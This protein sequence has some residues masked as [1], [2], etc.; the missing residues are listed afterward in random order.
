ML[1][2]SKKILAWV[3]LLCMVLSVSLN[4]YTAAA[5]ETLGGGQQ[6][7]G[8]Q[9]AGENTEGQE[10]MNN[11]GSGDG[12]A[13][14]DSGDIANTRGDTNGGED[15][16]AAKGDEEG[17][18]WPQPLIDV[19]DGYYGPNGSVDLPPVRVAITEGPAL[20][21]R[22]AEINASQVLA[23]QTLF[24]R[25]E[26]GLAQAKNFADDP[27]EEP[28]PLYDDFYDVNLTVTLP[29]GL[30]LNENGKHY[31]M[32]SVPDNRDLSVPHTYTITLPPNIPDNPDT[33]E[34]ESRYFV[35]SEGFDLQI[36]V[37]N[38]G[39]ANS[40]NTYNLANCVTLNAKFDVV[41]KTSELP[42]PQNAVKTYTYPATAGMDPITT[43]TPDVW[44]VNK[45]ESKPAAVDQNSNIVTYEWQIDVGLVKGTDENGRSILQSDGDKYTRFGADEVT[46]M[47]LSDA[48][49]V[50]L[51]GSDT[52]YDL[53]PTS[54]TIKKTG[55]TTTAVTLYDAETNLLGQPLVVWGA[56]AN[57]NLRLNETTAV[58]DKDGDK[59]ADTTTPTYTSYIVTA[60]YDVSGLTGEFY[61]D[62]LNTLKANNK[63]DL[64]ATLA[65]GKA[66][67][68]PI[69]Q[70]DDDDADSVAT[71][72]R[73]Q[74]AKI[75]IDKMLWTVSGGTNAY[76]GEFGTITYTL[77]A[78]DDSQFKVYTYDGSAYSEYAN[79]TSVTITDIE[80]AY[81]VLPLPNGASYKIKE[82]IDSSYANQMHFDSVK[83]KEAEAA[84]SEAV[85]GSNGEVSFAVERGEEWTVTFTN[86]E[87]K[88]KIE[89]TKHDEK[90][91]PL[92]NTQFQL[93]DSNGNVVKWVSGGVE[94]DYMTTNN[95]GKGT[96]T[97]LPYGTYTLDEIPR[98]GYAKDGD[99]PKTIVIG[100][101]EGESVEYKPTYTN[102]KTKA[103]LTLTKYVGRLQATVGTN[104]PT[105]GSSNKDRFSFVLQRTIKDNPS[106]TDWETVT[107]DIDGNDILPLSDY[108]TISVDVAATD[109]SNNP[110]KYRWVET[111]TAE[112]DGTYNYYPV[113]ENADGTYT[114]KPTA[115]TAATQP[116]T[117]DVGGTQSFSMYNREKVT[118]QV[119]KHYYQ[120][121]TNGG[122][123]IQEV[124]SNGDTAPST[125]SWT[126]P[127]TLYRY[128]GTGDP[129]SVSQ[130]T[131]I[132]T[133]DAKSSSTEARWEDLIVF[134]ENATYTY[135]VK[136]TLPTAE[137]DP[138]SRFTYWD[139]NTGLQGTTYVELP[140][141]S[142]DYYVKVTMTKGVNEVG[143]RNYEDA[144]PIR[145]RKL[146]GTG[147]TTLAG[148]T[149]TIYTDPDCS[150]D[151]IAYD[152]Q[153]GK[154]LEKITLPRDTTG[155]YIYLK[156]GQR[157]YYKEIDIPSGYTF[158]NMITDN[159]STYGN[160]TT[161]TTTNLGTI[162]LTDLEQPTMSK[163]PNTNAGGYRY[164]T[165]TVRNIKD[166]DVQFTKKSMGQTRDLKGAKFAVFTRTGTE[167]NYSYT[168]VKEFDLSSSATVSQSLPEGTYYVAEIKTPNADDNGVGYLN[169][170]SQNAC[171][172]YNRVA[173]ALG[174][175]VDGTNAISYYYDANATYGELTGLTF[176]PITVTSST[177]SFTFYNIYL[178]EKVQVQKTVD[179]E[180]AQIAGFNVEIWQCDAQGNIISTAP[181]KTEKTNING[182]AKF[183]GLP[184]YDENGNRLYYKVKEADSSTWTEGLADQYYFVSDGQVFQLE[185]QTS[186]SSYNTK[187]VDNNVLKVNNATCIKI[188]GTK[189]Q[190]D[191]WGGN[192]NMRV[193]MDG[194]T[195]GLFRRVAAAE[196]QTPNA[197]EYVDKK[198]SADGGQVEFGGLPRTNAE[199]KAYEYALVE[200]NSNSTVYFPYQENP[201]NS[202][203]SA[204]KDN[205]AENATISDADL[206]EYNALVLSASQ[207]N[208]TDKQYDLGEI[209]N[210]NHWVQFHLKKW[211]DSH[212]LVDYYNDKGELVVKGN[213]TL[214]IGDS[215]GH[216]RYDPE[217]YPGEIPPQSGDTALDDCTFSLYRY[218]LSDSQ[219]SVAFDRGTW[220]LVGTYSSGSLLDNN[221]NPYPG[222]FITDL[223]TG[224]NDNYVYVLVE[225]NVGPNSCIIN[226]HY[227]Y[228][229]WYSDGRT[230]PVT[231][232]V[233]DKEIERILTYT[234]DQVNHSDLLN[235]WKAG[236]GE[237][238]ILLAALR[239]TKWFDTYDVAGN[240]KKDY[241]PLYNVVFQ[242]RL[243]NGSDDTNGTL[244]AEMTTKKDTHQSGENEIDLASAQTGVYQLVFGTGN[245]EGKVYL[246]EYEVPNEDYR[247][248]EVTDLIKEFDDPDHPGYKIYGIPVNII[249]TEEPE[250]Y[251]HPA[252]IHETYLI[253]V[254][255]DPDGTGN[256]F[257]FYSDLYFVKTND[258]TTPL[259]EYQEGRLWHATEAT[260][261][262]V[263]TLGESQFRRIVNYPMIN[264]A[265]EIH[266]VGYA[267]T[268]A[269]VTLASTAGDKYSEEIANGNYGAVVLPGITMTLERWDEETST[270]KAWDYSSGETGNWGSKTFVTEAP[271]GTYFFPKGLPMGKYRVYETSLGEHANDYENAYL[272]ANGHYREFTVGGEPIDVYMANPEKIDLKLTKKN[273]A[274]NQPVT[275]MTFKLGTIT[276]TDN[277]DGTYT[278]SNLPTGTY[279]LTETAPANISIENFAARFAVAYPDL[280]A[281]VGTG[282]LL[283]YTYTPKG[284]DGAGDVAITEITPW[285]HANNKLLELEIKNPVKTNIVVKKYDLA[286]T[287]NETALASAQ[288]VY[289]YKPFG[290]LSGNISV[291]P[292]E[293][294][295]GT[296]LG[297]VTSPA[298]TSVRGIF[299]AEGW[300]EKSEFNTTTTGYTI[301]NAEPGIYAFYEYNAPNG[302]D[303]LVY[304]KNG[305]NYYPIYVAVVTGGMPVSVTVTPTN[306]NVGDYTVATKFEST[307]G[308]AVNVA[309]K[310]PK[311]ASIKAMKSVNAGDLG[312]ADIIDWSVTLNL[313]DSETA[314]NP[315]GSATITKSTQSNEVTFKK[316]SA[317]A[318]FSVG[319]TY[320][321]EEVVNATSGG[322]DAAHFVWASYK[323]GETGNV[324]SVTPGNRYEIPVNSA[325]IF[326]IY[327]TNNYLYGRVNFRKYDAA[328]MELLKDAEFEVQHLVN[329]KWETI[330]GSK[331]EQI[332][333]NNEGTGKYTAFI[334]LDSV[335]ETTY[336]IHET[337]APPAHVIDPI[338]DYIEVK[339][340]FDPDND[341]HGNKK[342]F[343]VGTPVAGTYLTN[344]T[345]NVLEITKYD[346]VKG[347]DDIKPVLPADVRFTLYHLDKTVTPNVWREVIEKEVEG[348]AGKITFDGQYLLIPYETYAVAETYANPEHFNRLDS[349]WVNNDKKTLSP[350]TAIKKNGDEVEVDAY[351]FY[352]DGTVSTIKFDAYNV[353]YLKPTI[354]KLDVGK[355]PTN[356]YARMDF[357]VYEV[358]SNFVANQANVEAL[359]TDCTNTTDLTTLPRIVFQGN[360]STHVTK[361]YPDAE[362]GEQCL[363]TSVVWES[364]DSITN[365]W[366]PEKNY[367]LVETKVFGDGAIYDTM[368]KNDPRVVWFLPIAPVAVP[369]GSEEFILANI[370]GAASV[371]LTKTVV[372]SGF[373]SVEEAA[374]KENSVV[375]TNIGTADEKFEVESLLTGDR[376]VIY[377]LAPTV[378]SKNQMLKSFVLTE[379]GLTAGVPY[380]PDYEITYLIVGGATQVLPLELGLSSATIKADVSY[381][382]DLNASAVENALIRTDTDVSIGTKLT[383]PAGT[384]SFEIEYYSPEV[385]E[386][387]PGYKLAEEFS[388]FPSTVYMTIKQ[389]PDGTVDVVEDED[390]TTHTVTHPAKEISQFTN[391]STASLKYDKWKNDGS[392][393]EEKNLQADDTAIIDVTQQVIPLVS[394]SKT[395]DTLTATAG[396]R[397]KYT[398]TVTNK[399]DSLKDFDKPVLVDILPTGVTY[400]I[401][402]G[403]PKVS[404]GTQG[405]TLTF[406]S[407][408]VK[409]GNAIQGPVIVDG[410]S[411][412]DT[413]KCVIFRMG[414][415][416]LKP[417]SSITIEFYAKV[418]ASAVAY[419]APQGGEDKK[420]SIRNDVYLSSTDKTAYHTE[421]NKFGYPFAVNL[422]GGV[423]TFGESIADA[424]SHNASSQIHEQGVHDRLG[425]E[426]KYPYT[427]ESEY[428]WVHDF[429]TIPV[430]IGNQLNLNKAVQGDQDKGFHTSGLGVATRTVNPATTTHNVSNGHVDWQLQINN[431]QDEPA[432]NIVVGDAIPKE[433][434]DANRKSHWDVIFDSF[435]GMTNNKVDVADGKYTV[436]YYTGPISEEMENGEIVY[437]SDVIKTDMTTARSWTT[438]SHPDLWSTTMPE[439]KESITGFIIVFKGGSNPDT[440]FIIQPGQTAL[441]TYHTKVKAYQDDQD[442]ADHRAFQNATNDFFVFYS[443]YGA[444]QASN[445]VSVTLMDETVQ[446][447]G[448]VWIDEDWDNKQQ[449]TGNRR[450]YSKYTLVNELAGSI[451]FNITD[452]RSSS[453]ET[454]LEDNKHGTNTNPG[455][456]ESI[457]HF[458][459]TNLGAA[460]YVAGRTL[461]GSDD[462]LNVGLHKIPGQMIALKGTDPFHYYL[463]AEIDDK[464]LLNVFSLTGR[465]EGHYMSDDPDHELTDTADNS[466]D[467][468]FGEAGNGIYSAY[469]FYI[470][471]SN[472]WDQSKDIG[473][474]SRRGL[475]ITKVAKDNPNETVTGAKFQMYGP[476]GDSHIP[477]VEENVFTSE[478]TEGEG[479]ATG[480]PLTFTASTVGEGDAAHTVYTIDPKGTVT[481]LVTDENGKIY[482]EG[483]NW[484]KEYDIQ[485]IEPDSDTEASGYSITGATSAGDLLGKV[486]KPG[487]GEGSAPT[488]D[489]VYTV[490]TDHGNGGFTLMVPSPDRTSAMNTDKVTVADPRSVKVKLNVE[491]Q[492]NSYSTEKDFIFTFTL[493]KKVDPNDPDFSW[494]TD[495]QNNVSADLSAVNSTNE[496]N[497]VPIDTKTVTIKGSSTGSS[498]GYTE[499]KE[500]TLY[501][502]GIYRF[503]IT[504]AAKAADDPE[505]LVHDDTPVKD[506]IVT[507]SWDD[508]LN[509]LVASVV[510]SESHTANGKTYE[511]FTNEYTDKIKWTPGVNKQLTGRPI[512]P[513][514]FKFELRQ[515]VTDAEGNTSEAKV[516][517]ATVAADGTVTFP[518]Q[519]YTLQDKG[520]HVYKIYEIAGTDESIS[521]NTEKIVVTATVI[522]GEDSNGKLTCTPTYDPDGK[523]FINTWSA[524]GDWTPVVKKDLTVVGIDD[525]YDLVISKTFEATVTC[526]DANFT[527][528]NPV[529][530][531]QAEV[532]ESGALVDFTWAAPGKVRFTQAD[533]GTHT[534]KIKETYTKE[535]LNG[536]KYDKT[537]HDV[538]VNVALHRNADG[539]YSNVLDVTWDNGTDTKPII[540]NNE[541]DAIGNAKFKV[542]K[543]LI[544]GETR[545]A[546]AEDQFTF[547]LLANEND[548]A[549]NALQTKT[550]PATEAGTNAEVVFDEITYTLAQVKAQTGGKFT[551]YIKEL[552]TSGH[553][554]VYDSHV[555]KVE[556]TPVD[557]GNGKLDCTP[558]YYVKD[559][560]G[561]WQILNTTDED[562]VVKNPTFTN[563]QLYGLKILKWLDDDAASTSDERFN[564]TLTLFTTETEGETTTNVAYTGVV[565][566]DLVF[567]GGTDD[568]AKAK[569]AWTEGKDDDGKGTGVY[570]FTLAHN[571]TVE[572]K[573]PIGV[574]Y[575]INEHGDGFDVLIEVCK[576]ALTSTNYA[577]FTQTEKY[578]ATGSIIEADGD[579]VVKYTN[580]RGSVLPLTGGRGTAPITAVGLMMILAALGCGMILRFRRKGD[581]G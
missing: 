237:G 72:Y 376:K 160:S 294:A 188:K 174:R 236:L 363:G 380:A 277:G 319:K 425:D 221:G 450:D 453:G 302:Y 130:L 348:D 109:G 40:I 89:I 489:S 350:I 314:T 37:G 48:L 198:N 217:H 454:K 53:N 305:A 2:R 329:G 355:Y 149:V 170:N 212:P 370:N 503:T 334:P 346:N 28:L 242:V 562:G 134:D 71:L 366:D 265:V 396:G 447:E 68:E 269:T 267:P 245:N 229:F 4:S 580:T 281:L 33:P 120:Y 374:D 395:S 158:M 465:G 553:N 50:F 191:G 137:T 162:D 101:G 493:N 419:D 102:T 508:T 308:T 38:N 5:D 159:S 157:Y 58:L 211:L 397:I 285:D 569:L 251:S 473:F 166:P 24:Y 315:V 463:G 204:W 328:T 332:K 532:E 14:A 272:K 233:G 517:E 179:G 249:E 325:D 104:W 13:T 208:I 391:K 345:G 333:Q 51:N 86:K 192:G 289:F 202:E 446:I 402:S 498:V 310:D 262:P 254:D 22:G 291:T 383:V 388:P 129:T 27:Y 168:F 297:N 163:R 85:E 479:F 193:P 492:F 381:Y 57:Q 278:F 512:V 84:D 558:V 91:Q 541:Y 471:Y 365:R 96:Y 153:T 451:G 504:E 457:R 263:Y 255:K 501:G 331:V 172:E 7:E 248:Y 288:F 63:V 357:K 222:Q 361:K 418:S 401:V 306:V 557:D 507:V 539:T 527:G 410:V 443:G 214:G 177:K 387:A 460:A 470:R 495:P 256:K 152:A 467:S 537:E 3:A 525:A 488:E 369:T 336:R 437:A 429:D 279:K 148:C 126:V 440:D 29:A 21:S 547:V 276:A 142:G 261:S 433:G 464:S 132:S 31:P 151:H 266:K 117:V 307:N 364:D 88:G 385:T 207:I 20:E 432:L 190:Q 187:D 154:R 8:E 448:D 90:G 146:V 373:E 67:A 311:K 42:Y 552:D 18:N 551:Y 240:R 135:Y 324:I 284:G 25:L 199:G 487:E 417:G 456:G 386:K 430:V 147:S 286:D 82:T 155:Q 78:A 257:R 337:V 247:E 61:D 497:A 6:V 173:T 422:S 43:I 581:E 529:L 469:P 287:D 97:D 111:I 182:L 115:T 201:K 436:W 358:S 194:A 406:E 270:W 466:L 513:G 209:I 486:T 65:N 44:G 169:P 341:P 75:D 54:V 26:Y 17:S 105:A 316:G 15:G 128:S 103:T 167:G 318:Y 371:Y 46:T 575:K 230:T 218:V 293:I 491:K 568:T 87:C 414:G 322:V 441:I 528:T 384:K 559:D 538:T 477:Q 112:E 449:S 216:R 59:T 189:I 478:R 100:D 133:K 139:L 362:T 344:A 200:I 379:N 171:N 180:D 234:M 560:N 140:A 480:T 375:G 313:Y 253:F 80:Q 343:T 244:I 131:E 335:N 472:R 243:D 556:V 317:T 275:G 107:K 524:S 119:V 60:K 79:A 405:E 231:C 49:K 445:P 175:K 349:I 323:I 227:E 12:A 228:T 516:A 494:V 572:L 438:E 536:V 150:D 215:D 161:T 519:T 452:G 426:P 338:N 34:D 462:Y 435:I 483:L 421:N 545:L 110:Y 510:Y 39:T 522:I 530:T 408:Q 352:N 576:N 400:E 542:D 19:A 415:D 548:T 544:S 268:S 368:V 416:A 232:T 295:E 176:T 99:W 359:V 241:N 578:T 76:N 36:F 312:N 407:V 475:E 206:K 56:G 239:L 47:S 66:P 579:Q 351:T 274:T 526:T 382:S 196:G 309:A 327:V 70:N 518:E 145:I 439:D 326:T 354:V 505:T 502:E 116:K 356:V 183:E 23:G 424:A 413:E 500:L 342:D 273:M 304:T 118:V 280:A 458:T 252:K 30:I 476:F 554:M 1:K 271:F 563:E 282:M 561:E 185:V 461:Y 444:V 339:L 431:G 573:L 164:K 566:E 283:G 32:T 390:G 474:R 567:S 298:A 127:V 484:W 428:V 114:N 570:T 420:A 260:G 197:W 434:D 496:L 499:F 543:I 98:A 564:F 485:E 523:T 64:T 264:T 77:T 577:V 574:Q 531:G 108:G 16:D 258:K 377:T 509:C 455:F 393:T 121:G 224:I 296:A 372:P 10:A 555:L 11:D 213:K 442:F 226:P 565:F 74:P 203:D 515:D 83:A 62:D 360:T 394:V 533:V 210:S 69:V 571:E 546:V 93:K 399:S 136:E 178:Q 506:A 235:S 427:T 195:I 94:Y 250:G 303:R 55:T 92:P 165:Y 41:D 122:T 300:T 106:E 9:P 225:D 301:S 81:Y 521:Y 184:L 540:F 412:S 398:L 514:E 411:Y 481:E 549:E 238:N 124:T 73:E 292:P 367:I 156:T 347:A 392:G 321:L 511:L 259:A 125:A 550:T 423:Y 144:I 219:T 35:T 299:K 220:D 409:E 223:E 186:G 353:P 459:F 534:Y 482:V 205:A 45:S 138:R 181:V 389:I 490:V 95:S 143:F 52:Q 404:T 520:T 340:K 320:Y 246:R 535:T 141:K 378:D 123:T 330:P 290:T 113:V 468:N 403:Y